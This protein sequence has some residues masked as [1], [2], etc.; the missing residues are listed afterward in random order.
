MKRKPLPKAITRP[1]A[2]LQKLAAGF[3]ADEQGRVPRRTMAFDAVE[4][5]PAPDIGKPIEQPR[6]AEMDQQTNAHADAKTRPVDPLAARRRALARRIVERHKN[7]A[8]L[9]G[10]VPLPAA[11][12]ASVA[13]VN[14]RMV[15]RLS[16][17]YGVPF[18]RDRT[19]ALII[20]LIAGAVPTGAG[21]AA[22]STLMWIVPGG[23]VW[24]LGA[25]ALTAGALT[26]GIGAVFV[27]SFETAVAEQD[28]Q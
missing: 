17:L 27:D 2:N 3:A 22:S 19:R 26:R 4:P 28:A 20:A 10:L 24:G 13:A 1:I 14:L 11:N 12:V 7:Y 8:A 16:E 21:L 18:E 6:R 15:K 9:G 5:E 23:L 25:A